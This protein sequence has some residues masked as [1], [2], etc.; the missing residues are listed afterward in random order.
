MKYL[1]PSLGQ[2]LISMICKYPDYVKQY[3]AEVGEIMKKL[4]STEIRMEAVGLQIASALFE[5]VGIDAD[6]LNKFLFQIFST[7]HFY[8]NNTR[9]KVIPVS[10]TRSIFIFFATF[11]VNF[12]SAALL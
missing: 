8:R 3:A 1:I 7:M 12:G 4:L 9:N 10:I 11:M 6:L 5:R 2:F